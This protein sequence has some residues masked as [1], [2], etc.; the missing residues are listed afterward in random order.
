VTPY[1]MH[2][3]FSR[4]YCYGNMITEPLSSNGRLGLPP[5]LR[6]LGIMS[7]YIY[8]YISYSIL[9]DFTLTL[10]SKHIVGIIIPKYL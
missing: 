8:I 7:Q 4:I 10:F 5:I 2:C 9:T 1:A 6:L 3:F